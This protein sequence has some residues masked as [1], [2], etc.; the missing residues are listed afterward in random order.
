MN[1]SP[2]LMSRYQLARARLDL[3]L[4]LLGWGLTL[5]FALR[6]VFLGTRLKRSQSVGHVA[7]KVAAQVMALP[8]K[9]R[10]RRAR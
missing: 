8:L 7:H 9:H 2:V 6:I 1:V 3:W 4:A 5:W 10:S